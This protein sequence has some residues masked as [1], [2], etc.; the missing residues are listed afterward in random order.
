MNVIY[1]T[2]VYMNLNECHS[3]TDDALAVRRKRW[4]ESGRSRVQIPAALSQFSSNWVMAVNLSWAPP[5]M[6]LSGGETGVKPEFTFNKIHCSSCIYVEHKSGYSDEQ[7]CICV[8]CVRYI[9][10]RTHK[11]LVVAVKQFPSLMLA[12]KTSNIEYAAGRT[13][14]G[15]SKRMKTLIYSGFECRK[16]IALQQFLVPTPLKSDCNE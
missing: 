16:N 13:F 8:H 10:I 2:E 15:W 4:L 12:K 7:E 14:L 11:T 1:T 3:H 5:L 9:Y 6:L